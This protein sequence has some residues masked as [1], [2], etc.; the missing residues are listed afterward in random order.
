MDL[1]VA[2]IDAIA[3]SIDLNLENKVEIPLF[4]AH[5]FLKG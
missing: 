2:E 5:F 1:S 4:Q 3:N